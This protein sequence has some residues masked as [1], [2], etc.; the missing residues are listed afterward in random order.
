MEKQQKP[1]EMTTSLIGPENA[2]FQNS[3]RTNIIYPE[4]DPE[5]VPNPDL[6]FY[7]FPKKPIVIKNPAQRKPSFQIF[8]SSTFLTPRQDIVPFNQ[9]TPSSR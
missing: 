6:A 7:P 8:P 3:R 4:P 9:F 1:N 2:I 5:S